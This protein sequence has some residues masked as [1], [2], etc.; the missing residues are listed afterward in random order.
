MFL[1][2]GLMYL[3]IYMKVG[4]LLSCVH[5]IIGKYKISEKKYLGIGAVH[6][7]YYSALCYIFSMGCDS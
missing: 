7:K 4:E 1:K 2:S 5:Q 3:L 6:N